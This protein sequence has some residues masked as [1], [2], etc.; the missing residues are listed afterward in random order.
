MGHIVEGVYTV[1]R[2]PLGLCFSLRLGGHANKAMV[3]LIK[4]DDTADCRIVELIE[5]GW[6]SDMRSAFALI[7]AI[8]QANARIGIIEY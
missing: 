2:Q 8:R 4:S 7:G 1:V 6:K 3:A 5:D